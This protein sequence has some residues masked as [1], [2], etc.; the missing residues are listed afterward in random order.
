L[1]LLPGITGSTRKHHNSG[2]NLVSLCKDRRRNKGLLFCAEPARIPQSFKT[3][4]FKIQ[5]KAAI[6]ATAR[7]VAGERTLS[8]VPGRARVAS[9]F[10][11][12]EGK[13][14][15]NLLAIRAESGALSPTEYRKQPRSFVHA[16]VYEGGRQTVVKKWAGRVLS[17]LAAAEKELLT[18]ENDGHHQIGAGG[19]TVEIE[20]PAEMSG[21]TPI[22][23][24]PLLSLAPFRYGCL[25]VKR[26][27][28]MLLYDRSSLTL[29][30]TVLVKVL[31]TGDRF[32]ASSINSP[33]C[34]SVASARIMNT[35]RISW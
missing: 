32:W 21:K 27:V 19:I 8:G 35:T 29:T 34:P 4:L 25:L 18:T 20:G 2:R 33:S 3:Q 24:L 16:C 23:H 1:W 10:V 11:W 31:N 28:K 15:K 7:E 5:L 30:G 13:P 12:R 9:T 14:L 17:L 22:S 26:Y 6:E